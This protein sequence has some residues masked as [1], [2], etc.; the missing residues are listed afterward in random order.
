[1]RYLFVILLL[2]GCGKADSNN[3]GYGYEYDVQG[4]TGLKL[5]SSAL[6]P[7][8]PD[9][10]ALST[11]PY[12]EN[13]WSKTQ[14]CTALS[15]TAPFV[16]LVK[17]GALGSDKAGLYLPDPSLI[18]LDVHAYGVRHEM[19]HYLLDVNTG[20]LDP[21]HKSHFFADCGGFS[22]GTLSR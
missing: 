7:A 5:R 9:F 21:D 12:Y 10:Q 19:V 13:A 22:F 18:L 15:A 14:E 1:M 11:P 4:A 16:I 20:D 17:V 6:D 2:A 8:D 3:H